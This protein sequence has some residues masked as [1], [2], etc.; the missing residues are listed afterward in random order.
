M[1]VPHIVLGLGLMIY[2]L[3]VTNNWLHWGIGSGGLVL[4]QI[5][6]E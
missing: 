5:T 4:A 3:F 1:H 6:R 2:P